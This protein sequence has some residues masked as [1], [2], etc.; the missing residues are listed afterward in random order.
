MTIRFPDGTKAEWHSEAIRIVN[1][2]IPITDKDIPRL[3][4][5][6]KDLNWPGASEIAQ[7]LLTLGESTVEPIR[8]ILK[9]SDDVWKYW[10]LGCL[11]ENWNISYSLKIA[12]ELLSIARAQDSD[13]AHVLALKI[14]ANC[15]I[16]ERSELLDLLESKRD[17]Q[18]ICD[19]EY[20]D[21]RSILEPW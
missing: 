5:W 17:F 13:E 16:G 11:V 15:M 19:E 12:D 4:E 8:G 2:D 9:G 7:Y 6:L 1:G 10:V 20:K 3:L 18:A 14:C 21:I